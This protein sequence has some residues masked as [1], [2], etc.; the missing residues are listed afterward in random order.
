MPLVPKGYKQRVSNAVSHYW[1]TL[2]TQAAKQKA[3]DADRGRRAAVIGGKQ[4][5]GFCELIHWL[6]KK[7]GLADTDVHLSGK[8]KLTIPG[9]YRPTKQWDIVV[10]HNGYLIA[11]IEFKSQ[12]GPSFGNNFNNRTEEALGT[13]EDFWTAFREGA[14]GVDKPR[15]WIGWLMLLEDCEKSHTEVD[16]LEKHFN[17]LPEFKGT[18]YTQRYAILTRKLILEK[19]YDQAA[20]L[21]ASKDGGPV[22]KFTEPVK[23]LSMHR[24]LTSLA[25]HIRVY[26]EGVG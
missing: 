15:P 21:M 25:G 12:R 23:D 22:G 10:V 24:F 7:N 8:A 3:G 14:F 9:F 17:V 18:S 13:A 20:F 19:K 16:V 1:E 2:S 4:M 11:A 5:D 26:L 6:C